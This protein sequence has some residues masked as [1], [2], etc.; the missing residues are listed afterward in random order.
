MTPLLENKIAL[1]TGASK[2][3]GA[4]VAQAYAR[5]GAQTVLL[6]RSAEGLEAVDDA[7][8][9]EGGLPPVLVPVDLREH[10][11]LDSIGPSLYERFGRLDIFVGNAGLLGK[12]GPLTHLDPKIWDDVMAVNVTANYRLLRSCEPLLKQSEAGRVIL[13][14]SGVAGRPAPYWGV[15][16]ISKDAVESMV[17][18]LAAEWRETPM[19]INAIDPGAT[20][21]HMRAAAMPGEDPEM[22]KAPEEVCETFVQLASA[23]Y[24]GTGEVVR[25]M[26]A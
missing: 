9:A 23:Q 17:Q 6:A 20:R 19:R 5:A 7:I 24:E 18:L 14:S 16:K 15:Y 26:G 3:I 4:A 2:G 21:T 10:D 12:L 11:R 25:C 22:V 1:I 13:V 8:R